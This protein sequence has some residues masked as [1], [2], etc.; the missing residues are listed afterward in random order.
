MKSFNSWL[1]GRAELCN[2]L[3]WSQ[4]MKGPGIYEKGSFPIRVFHTGKCWSQLSALLNF[5]APSPHPL[6]VQASCCCSWMESL[7]KLGTWHM[8]HL[9]SL[10]PLQRWLE[11]LFTCEEW[12]WERLSTLRSLNC[13]R[14][15]CAL[16]WSPSFRAC[17]LIITASCPQQPSGWFQLHQKG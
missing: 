9:I 10:S 5:P 14:H 1:P 15:M 16:S 4:I 7:T 8:L 17:A 6:V 11:I 3:N 2:T 13:T 12:S